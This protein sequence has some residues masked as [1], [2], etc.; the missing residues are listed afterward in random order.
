MTNHVMKPPDGHS[1]FSWNSQ[2]L[3]LAVGL[4]LHQ[5]RRV[6]CLLHVL[7]SLQLIVVNTLRQNWVTTEVILVVDE[8]QTSQL[9]FTIVHLFIGNFMESS[10]DSSAVQ[11]IQKSIDDRLAQGCRPVLRKLRAPSTF[12]WLVDMVSRASPLNLVL[13]T[14][15]RSH[16]ASGFEVRQTI[17]EVFQPKLTLISSDKFKRF[18]AFCITRCFSDQLVHA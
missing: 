16:E 17:L 15:G 11:I 12:Q 18:S 2:P 9:A 13:H 14:F 3:E 4:K 8:V 5:V 6:W 7:L 10:H 1:G